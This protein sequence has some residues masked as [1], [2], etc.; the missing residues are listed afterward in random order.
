MCT[1]VRVYDHKKFNRHPLVVNMSQGTGPS[2][3][4]RR[5]TALTPPTGITLLL[6]KLE[7]HVHLS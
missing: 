7:K 4:S 1:Y 5:K 2:Q 3:K 6:Q